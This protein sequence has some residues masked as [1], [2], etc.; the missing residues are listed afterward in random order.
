MLCFV[1]ADWPLIGGDFTVAGLNV[2]WPKKT[3]SHIVKP[4]AVDAATAERVKLTEVMSEEWRRFSPGFG[5]ACCPS[6]VR[7]R[8]CRSWLRSGC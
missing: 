7:S 3:A 8:P 1:E 2:L 5:R 6:P 4:G